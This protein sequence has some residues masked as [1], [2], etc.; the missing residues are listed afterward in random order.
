MATASQP[1]SAKKTRAA[2]FTHHQVLSQLVAEVERQR[3]A[4]N[5]HEQWINYFNDLRWW[6]RLRWI[7]LGR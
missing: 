4:L 7:C 2:V 3:N 1:L 6:G 5:G